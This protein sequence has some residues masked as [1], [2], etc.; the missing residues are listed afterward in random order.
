MET[1]KVPDYYKILGVSE[2]AS[3][4]E[5]KKAYR[6]LAKKY[7]PDAHPND[8]TA[9]ERFKEI[10]EA[11][12]VLSDKKKRA[13]YDQMRKLGAFGTGESA[14]GWRDISFEDLSSIF[15][16]GRTR[17][18]SSRGAFSGGF[19][20]SDFFN[21]FFADEEP[22]F[23]TATH[24]PRTKG[25]DIHA[26]I[27][28]PFD[29]ALHGGKQLITLQKSQICPSCQGRGSKKVGTLCSQ[30]NG[31]GTVASTQK[32]N[33]TIPAGIEDGKK[34]KL[35]GQ[36]ES[37]PNVATPGDLILTVH[38]A[39]HPIFERKGADIY[40]EATINAVQAM[41]GTK[42]RVQKIDGGKVELKVPA[43][44]QPGKLLKLKGLGANIKGKQGDYY[45]RINVTVPTHLNEKSKELLK[46]FAKEAG[47]PL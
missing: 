27:T 30:C 46:K 4:A 8:K 35:R 14:S 16:R 43:G 34:I 44:T 21:S 40:S 37:G 25:Q 15:G 24:P 20:F 11:Y 1:M 9:E 47:I 2:N 18:S 26:E 19:S 33:V 41:L 7:H 12:A 31:T 23:H 39:K 10:S 17:T 28:I 42:I 3:E 32:I 5:I 22:S 38:V 45:V 29:V 36:G 6:E 13:E